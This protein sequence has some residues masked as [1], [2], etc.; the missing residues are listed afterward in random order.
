MTAAILAVKRRFGTAEPGK[1]WLWTAAL[2][3]AA[4]FV[5]AALPSREA[6]GAWWQAAAPWQ[7][8]FT[9][10]LLVGLATGVGAVAVFFV[11]SVPARLQDAM[12]GFGAG[13]MLAATSFSLILPG[14]EVAHLLTQS[15]AVATAIVASGM[16]MGGLFLFAADRF[17]P[18]EHFIK[19]REGGDARRLRRI[20]LFVLA[21]ALHNLP[22]GL[23]VGVAFGGGDAAAS[24]LAFGIGLQNV[25]EG[26]AVALALVAVGYSRAIAFAVA[27]ATGLIEPMAGLFGAVMVG[28]A[29][30]LLPWGLAFAA[31]A[32]LFVISHEVIPESHRRGH[33]TPATTG[34]L[35]G[36][37][38]MMM[39]D[40][41]L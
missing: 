25:P 35:A 20:W 2:L 22:E 7:R 9:A 11:S 32:M 15:T 30:W 24:R 34:I 37:V 28:G 21:I 29:Q 13:V 23:A 10:S 38:V 6:L 16:G 1:R 5:F 14:I 12:L 39:L 33:E 3:L 27:L 8:G 40:T 17:V 41:A 36:F 4:A 19:G 18:H 31:G 26:L